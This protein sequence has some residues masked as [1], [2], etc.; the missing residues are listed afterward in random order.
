MVRETKANK[1]SVVKDKKR[2]DGKD[3]NY[4]RSVGENKLGGAWVELLVCCG[5]PPPNCLLDVALA[6]HHQY[7]EKLLWYWE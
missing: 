1:H 2:L 3:G 7:T 5:V 4:Q 6:I